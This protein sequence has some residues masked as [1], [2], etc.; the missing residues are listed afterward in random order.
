MS[1]QN[2]QKSSMTRVG[3]AIK[4]VWVGITTILLLITFSVPV[5]ANGNQSN[6]G[7]NQSAILVAPTP[8]T[9]IHIYPKPDI[10]Q[11]QLG[12]GLAGDRITVLEQVGSNEGYTWDYVKFDSPTKPKGWIRNEFVSFQTE[13]NLAESS[14]RRSLSDVVTRDRNSGSRQ[15]DQYDQNGYQGDRYQGDRYQGDRYQGNQSPINNHQR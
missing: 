7:M 11:K 5:L 2:K 4:L 14:N 15:I 9:Q 13:T 10:Q 8:G 6:Q 3:T 12:H 1:H